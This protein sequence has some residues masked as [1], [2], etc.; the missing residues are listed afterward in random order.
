MWRGPFSEP[1]KNN[2]GGNMARKDKGNHPCLSE[3][4]LHD[5]L[6]PGWAYDCQVLNEQD[7]FLIYSPGEG[8]P[9][10]IPLDLLKADRN[11]A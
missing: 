7:G 5:N 2:Q 4:W 3:D 8:E 6:P 10:F 11:A 9:L 1:S